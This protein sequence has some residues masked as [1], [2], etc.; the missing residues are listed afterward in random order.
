V[1][2]AQGL[3]EMK[4]TKEVKELRSKILGME[5][6]MNILSKDLERFSNERDCNKKLLEKIEENIEFLRKSKAAVSLSEFKKIKQQKKLVE[7]RVQ[8][9]TA[10]TQPIE[11]V[12]DKK[13]FFHKQEIEKFEQI[14]RLQF[15]NNILE[16]PSDRRKKA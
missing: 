12:L 6:E 4:E 7:M 1:D 3:K 16:F 9:Y 2:I 14:Y 11:R 5:M 13:E 15:K 10:K 8:Y